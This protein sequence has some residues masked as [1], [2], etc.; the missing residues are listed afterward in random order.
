MKTFL[1]A[2]FALT[3]GWSAAQ[4]QLEKLVQLSGTWVP[5]LS[6]LSENEKTAVPPGLEISCE[7][8]SE[9]NGVYCIVSAEIN[10]SRQVLSS[11]LLAYNQPDDKIY[12]M[13]YEGPRVVM[14]SGQ[15]KGNDLHYTDRD[16]NGNKVQDGI[17]SFRNGKL[18]QTVTR[19]ANGQEQTTE[20][21]YVKKE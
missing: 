3:I 20:M 21:T 9:T 15:F 11:E 12:L 13:L 18:H 7:K 10:G 19:E 5:D 1:T 6:A 16:T 2:L 8:T 4:S 14:G 17:L